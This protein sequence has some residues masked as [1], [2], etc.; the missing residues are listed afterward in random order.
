MVTLNI[1]KMFGKKNS[2][3]KNNYYLGLFLKETEGIG[4]V[5]TK[6]TNGLELVNWRWFKY[7]NGWENLSQD[8]DNLLMQFESNL[9]ITLTQTIFFLYSHAINSKTKEVK[10][11][12]LRT[13]KDLTK[14][15]DLKPLGYIEVVDAVIAWLENK[16]ESSIN[17]VIVEIDRSN[18]SIFII[19]GSKKINIQT[20]A[21]TDNIAS[22]INNAIQ[23]KAGSIILPSRFILYNF[24]NLTKDINILMSYRWDRDLFVQLPRID[25]FKEEDMMHA[26]TSLFSSQIMVNIKQNSDKEMRN[27]T[28][29]GFVI[30][31]ETIQQ[32]ESDRRMRT[33]KM[34]F[35]NLLMKFKFLKFNWT[36]I[37]GIILSIAALVSIELVLHQADLTITLPA[38]NIEQTMKY[39]IGSK[40]PNFQKQQIKY[41][42]SQTKPTNGK[43]AIGEK[44]KGEVTI[45]NF[46]DTD[47]KFLKGTII[48]GSGKQYTIDEEIT[49][50]SA[51]L[52]ADGSAKIPGKAKMGV[53]AVDIGNEG[54]LSKGQRFTFKDFPVT[55]FFA[56]NESN[57][58]G[59]SKKEVRTVAKKDL[60]ELENTILEKA[61]IEGNDRINKSIKQGYGYLDNLIDY[62]LTDSTFS[63]EV[64]EEAS[65]VNIKSTII[66][67]F[68]VYKKND[69]NNLAVVAL[70]DKIKSGLELETNKTILRVV[71]SEVSEGATNIDLLVKGKAIVVIDKSKIK[72]Q[73]AGKNINE[74][75]QIINNNL[76]A[77]G[78]NLQIEPNFIFIKD[79][80]P[81]YLNNILIEVKYN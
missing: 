35:I 73:L 18:I 23:E 10:S 20:T 11:I 13:I 32:S 62:Q 38:Q 57:L 59:G 41:E 2:L 70:K 40:D 39:K 29:M 50:K 21:R 69:L 37:A 66:L 36:I 30:G 34:N 68:Y 7:S 63:K 31:G 64:G 47:K 58:S 55:L 42:I 17:S 25:L 8:V 9:G 5:M 27:N 6:K 81:W 3:E 53:T 45:H 72:R 51:S 78:Y 74:T 16:E 48:V 49:V 65:D 19:R 56:I 71:Q 75:K 80:I 4:L 61:K 33:K 54:N 1:F 52:V 22:D 24:Y 15:L 77:I 79:R 67:S 44:A 43:K 12:Y 26:L 14:N 60:D 46:D 28:K 76:H